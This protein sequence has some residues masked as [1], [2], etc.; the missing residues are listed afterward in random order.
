MVFVGGNQFLTGREEFV[1][2]LIRIKFV[3]QYAIYW[4]EE[5]KLIN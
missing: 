5:K 4:N 1:T 3:L 2:K